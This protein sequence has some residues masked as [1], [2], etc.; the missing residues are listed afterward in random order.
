M[1]HYTLGIDMGTS[2]VKAALLDLD[3]FQ[4]RRVATCPYDNAPHQS[5][6]MLWAA[7][8]ATIR[9]AVAGMDPRAV[10]GM[11]ISGQ[12]HGTVLYDRAGRIIDPLIN[13]QDQRGAAP[14]ARYGG[15]TTVDML[16]ELLDGPDFDDLGLDVLP[17]GYLGATLFYIKENEPGLF[18]RI[19]HVALPGDFIRGKLLGGS[20]RATDPTNACGSGLFNTRRRQWH[21]RIIAQ[22]GLPQE[23]LPAVYDSAAVAGGLAPEVAHGVNLAPGTPVIYGGG[24]NQ[25]SLLGNGLIDGHSPALINIGT[26][27]QVSQIATQYTRQAGVETRCYFNG[28]YAL[29]GASR[30]GGGSYAQLHGA[31]QRRAG[32]AIDYREMDERAAQVAVGADGLVFQ[33]AAREAAGGRAAFVGRPE[34]QDVGRQARAV[35]EGVL[36]DLYRL[37][38]PTFEDGPGF[39]VGAGKGL[40]NSPVWAQMAADV[41]DFPIKITNFENAVWGAALIA[42]V[43]V[44]AVSD[45]RAAAA[46]IAYSRQSRPTRGG[47]RSTRPSSRTGKGR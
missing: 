32:R 25:M 6:E 2:G 46:T 40:Q 39:M 9:E 5:S 23:I 47:R 18:Q 42:A 4:L 8:A 29:V 34:L 31:L 17:S 21:A 41:F 36:L 28:S 24:D 13:W 30:G 11:S 15:R 3:T 27:A 43:G 12:M 26:G 7:T 37:R 14:L 10:A 44:G 45:L 1:A 22:L 33:L 38:P 20:D 35:M 16:R 19:H